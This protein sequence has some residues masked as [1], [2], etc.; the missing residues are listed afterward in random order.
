M[1]QKFKNGQVVYA[2]HQP[3]VP[4]VVSHY[5]GRIYYCLIPSQDNTSEKVYFERELVAALQSA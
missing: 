5:K 2:L 1:F 4:M 3:S